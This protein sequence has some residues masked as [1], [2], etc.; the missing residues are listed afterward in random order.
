MALAVS[1]LTTANGLTVH[2]YDN[3]DSDDST[4]TSI[5]LGRSKGALISPTGTHGFFQ[6]EGTFGGATAKLQGSND[7]TNWADLDI[8]YTST[9]LTHTAAGGS[10]FI[11]SCRYIRP[12]V[13]GG[14]SEDLNIYISIVQ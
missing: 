3:I 1:Q 4:P 6:V 9:A 2:T 11:A 5:E 10:E 14:T 7:G 8:A 12:L 13:T